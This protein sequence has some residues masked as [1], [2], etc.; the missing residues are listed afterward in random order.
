MAIDMLK[1]TGE[2]AGRGSPIPACTMEDVFITK[3][4]SKGGEDGAVTQDVE[5]VFKEW[6]SATSGR[7]TRADVGSV[8][9]RTSSGTS[10]R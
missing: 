5:F 7:T 9:V 3:V 2:V 4:A 1:Q 10:E 8:A 6:R